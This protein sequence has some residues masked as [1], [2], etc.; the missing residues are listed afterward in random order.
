M[1]IR[2]DI[3]REG[4]NIKKIVWAA[5]GYIVISFILGFIWHLVLFKETY[6]TFG[7]YTRK[8]PIIL[9][10]V[11]SMIIQGIIL[12]HLYPKYRGN[13]SGLAPALTFCFLMG[14]FFASGTVIALAA[15]SE[16]ANLTGWFGYS[17]SFHLLQFGLVALVFAFVFDRT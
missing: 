10:G 12:A 16:I 2:V 6:E 14:F 3:N 9:L 5:L 13:R 1:A 15:K 11:L 8:E 17:F 4:I 7:V